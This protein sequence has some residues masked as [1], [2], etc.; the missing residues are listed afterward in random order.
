[1]KACSKCGEQ[2][3]DLDFPLVRHKSSRAS[4][5][6]PCM[7]QYRRGIAGTPARTRIRRWNIEN[8]E[9]RTAHKIVERAIN[10]GALVRQPCER[11][12]AVRSHAHHDNYA[13][14]LD[15]MWLCHKHHY[16]RHEEIGRPMGTHRRAADTAVQK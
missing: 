2:R 6:K 16:R 13:A 8:Q 7:P 10:R 1:M 9:K 14:P 15:V 3:D 12:G 5:C 4:V 11:C